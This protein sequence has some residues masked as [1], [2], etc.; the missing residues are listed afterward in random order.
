L[1]QQP[2]QWSSTSCSSAARAVAANQHQATEAAAPSQP[3]GQ[4]AAL[5]RCDNDCHCRQVAGGASTRIAWCT[6]RRGWWCERQ[7]WCTLQRACNSRGSSGSSA[8]ARTNVNRFRA[9]TATNTSASPGKQ[10]GAFAASAA[11]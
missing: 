4:P 7:K 3:A 5:H 9:A 8:R 1:P 11:G 10:A 6:S 2:S